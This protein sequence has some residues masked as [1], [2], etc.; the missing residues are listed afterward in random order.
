MGKHNLDQFETVSFAT[1][2]IGLIRIGTVSFSTFLMG[3]IRIFCVTHR[4]VNICAKRLFKIH[5][6]I[7][8]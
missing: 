2:F 6:S 1:Y 8:M 7:E 3:L 5:T 4:L